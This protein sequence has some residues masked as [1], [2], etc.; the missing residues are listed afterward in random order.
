MYKVK[1]FLYQPSFDD[2]TVEKQINMFLENNTVVPIDIAITNRP[3][4]NGS[5]KAVYAILLY[6]EE[7]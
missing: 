7:E 5:C 1:A 2:L 3:T 4:S 6:K